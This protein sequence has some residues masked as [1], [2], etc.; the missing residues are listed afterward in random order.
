[1]KR[2]IVWLVFISV[3]TQTAGAQT[4]SKS[5][6]RNFPIVVSMQF[7][8][9]KALKD[10][11]PTFKNVG[12]GIGSEI[13]LGS[14]HNWAQQFQLSWYRDKQVGN[15][16]LLYTQSAWRPTIV[17]HFYAELKAGFGLTHKFRPEQQHSNA[18][19]SAED[20]EKWLLIIP[21]GVSV[22]YNKFSQ[23]TYLAP[24]IS[25]QLLVDETYKKGLPATANSLFQVGTRI[26]LENKK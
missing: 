1:M 22:G 14:K 5:S 12:F 23:Q 13:A 20:R 10:V 21:V 9:M 18:G 17:S 15:A 2:S 6:Y 4:N 11:R 26:H 25:Y 3:F 19:G 7:H 24:F 8:S 16:V